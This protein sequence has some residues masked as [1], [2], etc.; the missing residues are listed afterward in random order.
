MQLSKQAW[1]L[2][3]VYIICLIVNIISLIVDGSFSVGIAIG[4]IVVIAHMALIVFD[5]A[6]LTVG[7][8]NIWSWVRTVL[9]VI[10]PVIITI[11]ILVSLTQG[12]KSNENKQINVSQEGYY[13]W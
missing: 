5:T 11:V 1:T 8:C 10:L 9:F 2:A 6:C 13:R 3:I 7:S 4:L 12:K